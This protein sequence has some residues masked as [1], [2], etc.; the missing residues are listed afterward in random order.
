MPKHTKQRP[1]GDY[2]VGYAKPPP[3]HTFQKGHPFYPRKA[4]AKP[5]RAICRQIVADVLDE[6]VRV[7]EK[8][9]IKRITSFGALFQRDMER[10][11]KA[12][13]DALLRIVRRAKRFALFAPP[14]STA[15]TGVIVLRETRE[16]RLARIRAHNAKIEALEA[17]EEKKYRSAKR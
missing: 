15:R 1:S 9:K 5:N 4:K 11:M 7:R 13:A 8:G 2:D 6:P 10:A 14:P 17:E 3:A 12:D 16:E